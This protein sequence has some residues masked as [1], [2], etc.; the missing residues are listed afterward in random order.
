MTV[1][2]AV[3]RRSY[4][5]GMFDDVTEGAACVYTR[6]R[7]T[8]IVTL[9]FP[10]DLSSDQAAAVYARMESKDDADQ[11]AR[12]ALR[13]DRDELPEDDSLRRLYDYV[14]GETP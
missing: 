6:D 11:A 10:A 14:L 8:G 2:A 5:A 13:A 3:M 12:A 4:T 7:S 1:I 9:D